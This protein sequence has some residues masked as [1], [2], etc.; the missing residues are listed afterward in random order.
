MNTSIPKQVDAIIVGAGFSGLYMLKRLKDQGLSAVVFESGSDVGGTWY[1]NRYPGARCDVESPYYSYSFDPELE[2]EWEWT[3]RYPAQEEIQAYLSHVTDRYGL[4]DDISF[5]TTVAAA[6]YD[7]ETNQWTVSTLNGDGGHLTTAKY[8]IMATGCLSASR[9]PNIQGLDQYQGNIYHT[10][11]WPNEKVD[12][13]GQKVAVIGTGSSGVQAIPEI[14][15]EASELYVFQRTPN[16]SVPAE[17]GPLDQKLWK[18]VKENYR[19][20]RQT[21]KETPTGLPFH[22]PEELATE[23]TEERRQEVFNDFWTAGG[24]RLGQCFGDLAVDAQANEHLANFIRGKIDEIVTDPKTAHLLKPHDH[25]VGTK[26]IT[27]GTN[28]YQTFNREHVKLVDAREAPIQEI[29]STG[30]STDSENYEVDSIVFATGFDAMTGSFMKMDIRGREGKSLRD[31]WEAGPK[32]YLGISASGFPNMFM[33]AGPGS[34]S[35]LTNM[36]TAIEQHVDWVNDHI[37]YMEK[38]QLERSEAKSESE[39]EW[40]DHVNAVSEM[41]LMHE[42]NSWYLGA[43]VPGKP[44]VFMPY[45][46]GMGGYKQICDDVAAK[47]YKGFQLV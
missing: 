3:E 35:V 16:F 1:W 21:A 43:N 19:E 22:P 32:T 18:D 25:P 38:H 34:P 23:A 4:R 17:N 42:A 13:T 47:E 30:V 26:R 12:F 28:Y 8:C 29:T 46:G 9:L 41:T 14:A 33:L 11:A 5:D 7:D 27:V 44:R 37:E 20:I 36:V 2:Q 10:G 39:E 31:H 45:A 24:F 15:D 6:T 40:V